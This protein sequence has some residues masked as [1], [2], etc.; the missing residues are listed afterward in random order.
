MQFK[1]RAILLLLFTV[2]LFCL[3]LSFCKSLR[4]HESHHHRGLADFIL[5]PRALSPSN[6]QSLSTASA[7]TSKCDTVHI[8][9]V[10]GGYAAT[11]SL[12]VVLKSILFYRHNPIHFHFIADSSAHL[13][14]TE[15][16]RTWRLPST[17]YS[18]YPVEGL[19]KEIEWIPNAHYSGYFG[20][21]KLV[22]LNILPVDS[23]ITLDT[24]IT[25]VNDI[26]KLWNYF[27]DI[28]RKKKLLGLVE[29]QSD[30][31]LGTIWKKHRP[32]P[33]VGRG[34]NTGVMLLDIARLKQISW[35]E[36]WSNVTA[37]NLKEYQYT[38]LADQDI[39]NAVIK[40]Y[41]HIVYTLPC[42]WNVQLSD[43]SHSEQCYLEAD[44]Y[45]IIH[46]NSPLKTLID[47]KHSPYFRNL[48]NT[49]DQYNGNLLRQGLL[50]CQSVSNGSLYNQIKPNDNNCSIFVQES[51]IT[52]RTHV[53][54]YGKQYTSYDQYDMSYITQLS[55]DRLQNVE[56]LLKHW[57]GP[58]T[59]VV[60]C[61]DSDLWYLTS[62]LN[63]FSLLLKRTNIAIHVVYKEG[64]L[65]P[66]NLLRNI[67]LKYSSTP[68]VFASDADF[69]PMFDMYNY[70]REAIKILQLS[71][72]KRALVVP[73]FESLQYKF[74]FPHDKSTLLKILQQKDNIKIFRHKIWKKGHMATNFNK[75]YKASNPYRISWQPD[76]EP[77]IVVNR[78]VSL[79]DTRFIGFGWNKVSHTMELYAQGYEF[80]VL[81]DA[82]IIHSPH[83]PS[84]D[85]TRYRTSHTYREC[86][87]ELK[88]D[89]IEGLMK[90]YNI[91][92][93]F[94]TKIL[95]NSTF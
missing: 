84:V 35:S 83:A 63:N 36:I 60:Y 54:Y 86:L 19:Q 38:S 52:Y 61:T 18:L 81:P 59:L 7:M 6:N 23:V 9:F 27:S 34:Y 1:I 91:S 10:V 22:L 74:Q 94:Y 95:N 87:N 20:L 69:L 64:V 32:W 33:A 77:Y 28:K 56:Q 29:N 62:Y 49:F 85:I 2:L 72:F 41:P 80:I 79:Y 76:F 82:F 67:A 43:H 11:K 71:A 65:Y 55:L 47:S 75:W 12:V 66:V 48:Y 73:A 45:N 8:A 44:Q 21:M 13:I 3:F 50:H 42:S 16:M 57:E 17:D 25:V 37:A 53:Y 24:D 31:Y 30:W 5:S 58:I 93:D 88:K 46:W 14:L 70:L 51:S 15:L 4:R 89:F 90:K 39:I 26:Q 78:N 40:E 68:Y 92:K